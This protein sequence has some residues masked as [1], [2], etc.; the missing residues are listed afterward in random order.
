[1]RAKIKNLFTL[2]N[3]IKYSILKLEKTFSK[4]WNAI[5]VAT[6]N[7]IT[8][9]TEHKYSFPNKAEAKKE[10]SIFKQEIKNKIV[11]GSI[12]LSIFGKPLF[13]VAARKLN[14]SVEI[15]KSFNGYGYVID[16]R[17]VNGWENIKKVLDYV[18]MKRKEEEAKKERAIRKVG[19]D[20]TKILEAIYTISKE[21]KRQRDIKYNIADSVYGED[22]SRNDRLAHYQIRNAKENVEYYYKLKQKGINFLLKNKEF[23]KLEIHE[24][25]GNDMACLYKGQFSFHFELENL[26]KFGLEAKQ[27]ST[28]I[29]GFITAEKIKNRMSI[30]TALTII[31]SL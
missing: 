27:T 17:F 15:E 12:S 5:Y 18:T 31:N 4:K 1:V 20:K 23:D 28:S 13:I 26:A 7:D 11:E 21:A 30:R 10:F 19:K 2:K 6:Y 24:V 22:K 8:I 3:M 9:T 29:N 14:I 16:N 25:N